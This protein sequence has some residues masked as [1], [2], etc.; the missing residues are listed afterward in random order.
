[1][2]IVIGDIT[3]ITSFFYIEWVDSHYLIRDLI[4]LTDATLFLGLL[5]ILSLTVVRWGEIERMAKALSQQR[6]AIEY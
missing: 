5:I 2:F 6:P 4:S 1:M 3:M